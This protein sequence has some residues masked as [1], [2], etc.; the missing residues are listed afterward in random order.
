LPLLL[1]LSSVDT[2]DD[3][4]RGIDTFLTPHLLARIR[5]YL[6]YIRLLDYS[7]ADDVQKVNPPLVDLSVFYTMRQ[8]KRNQFS[9]V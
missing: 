9:F 8:K 2:V 5:T 1:D 7:V 6:G 4:Y 3:T